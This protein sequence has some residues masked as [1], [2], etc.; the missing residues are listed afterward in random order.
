MSQAG[1]STLVEHFAEVD[2]PRID[3]TKEHLLIDMI[4]IAICAILCGADDWVAVAKFGHAKY[5]WFKTFLRLPNGNPSHDTFGRVCARLDA[6][7]F[8][9]AFL[10]W[11]QA[12]S[13]LTLEQIVAM[14]GKTLRRSHD[15]RLG[16]GA[17]AMVS[18]WATANRLVLGPVKTDEKSNEI[19][20]IPELLRVL[21]LSGCIVT[22]DAMGCQ[23][24]IVEQIV[25]QGA[26]YLIAVKA[27]Q[28]HL[29]DD[30]RELFADARETKFKGIRHDHHR[31][32][33][34]G[35]GRIEIR[36]CWTMADSDYL[37]YLRGRQ[38]WKGLPT[39]VMVESQRR[40]G[41]KRTSDTRYFIASL[42]NDA[43][44]A[45]HTVRSHWGIENE[46][47]WV[48]DI[49]FREDDC[50]VRKDNA[51]QNFAVLRHIA[52][53]LLKQEKTTPRGTKNKRFKAGWDNDYLL[54]LLSH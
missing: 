28:G 54:K 30:V 42:D 16:Q 35:H 37:D 3:R 26:D 48:L 19:T 4:V 46:L 34:K 31:T 53:N 50:R 38:H 51:P 8:H 29:Y 7:S 18:V 17:I 11:I 13:V 39:L 47:H 14:D 49:A 44:R 36:N 40:I 2:D 15:K 52:L 9:Q 43:E 10:N 24:K 6:E 22:I 23:T 1:K 25:S 27:N 20:A 45:L 33:N 41:R 5:D 12:V 21:E 32:T